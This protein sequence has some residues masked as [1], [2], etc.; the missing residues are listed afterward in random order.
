MN[1]KDQTEVAR[2]KLIN[3][4]RAVVSDSEEL[5]RAT[6]GQAGERITAARERAEESLRDAKQRIAEL[7]DNA[8]ERARVAARQTDEYVRDHPWESIGIAGAVGILVGMLISR[9]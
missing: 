9:R 4:F 2:E 5:L 6:A 7:E 1:A 3:D 8:F